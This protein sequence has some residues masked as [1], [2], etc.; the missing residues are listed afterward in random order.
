MYAF[1]SVGVDFT[2]KMT[3]QKR[4]IMLLSFFILI[5]FQI[6]IMRNWAI[7]YFAQ[8][9]ILDV[10]MIGGIYAFR[11]FEFKH[12]DSINGIFV[13]YIIGT[14]FGELLTLLVTVTVFDFHKLSGF[15][16]IETGLFSI[17]V[18]SFFTWYLLNITIKH[19][20]SKRYLIIGK[21]E[22]LKDI[23]NEIEKESMR[24]ISVYKYIN[25]S[26]A[27]LEV[28][29][30]NRNSS[31]DYKSKHFDSILIGN[32]K[33]A[34]SVS[35]ILDEAKRE[36]IPIEYFPNIVEDV[37]KRVPIEIIGD[38]ED[39]Y[40]IVFSNIDRSRIIKILDITF[41]F[42]ILIILSPFVLF[43]ILYILALDGRPLFFKQ[44]RI[45]IDGSKFYIYKFRT[46]DD[47]EGKAEPVMTKSGKLLRMTRL[48]EI[49]QFFNVLKGDMSIVGPRPDIVS[50]YDY[51]MNNIPFYS[52]RTKVVPGI[53]GNAQVFY[54]Y[55]DRLEYEPFA[56][57]LSYDLYYI[58]HMNFEMYVEIALKTIEVMLFRKGAK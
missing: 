52:Y 15:V 33:L 30:K 4:S 12:T 9:V 2:R 22:H 40:K 6:L 23:M 48:N 7:F 1:C 53:T 14:I 37:L 16:F 49:P 28:E 36:N 5:A 35:D 13:S 24:K 29:I 31:L 25:P 3:F 8:I 26:P 45:G 17:F 18:L 43:S 47:V 11:G 44:E 42:L 32:M 38:F 51:C 54:H 20:P 56:N 57:R 10:F 21:E 34:N 27:L 50:T 58:K 41:S 55:V 19:L 46:M 39:Y